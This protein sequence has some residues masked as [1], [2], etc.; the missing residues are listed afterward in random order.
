M[1]EQ[2]SKSSRLNH[3]SKTSKIASSRSSGREAAAPG[4]ELD[5]AERPELLALRQEGEH[6]VV[7][8]AEMPVERRLRNVRR[9]D[10][11]VHADGADAA[12]G[13]EVV[14][15]VE[16]ALARGAGGRL[17]SCDCLAHRLS[18]ARS[19]PR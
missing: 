16:D 10:H 5:E 3:S 7:L 19:C 18:L 8:G 9:L 11:L 17:G 13:E 15:A 4:L 2:A 1:N 14:G 12:A 6:E